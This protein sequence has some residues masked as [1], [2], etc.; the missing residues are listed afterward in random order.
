MLK[1]S[2]LCAL[3]VVLNASTTSARDAPAV[4]RPTIQKDGFVFSGDQ[5]VSGSDKSRFIRLSERLPLSQLKKRFPSYA[6]RL[7]R[8]SLD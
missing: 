5:V 7:T 3:A 1:Q 6:I 4:V 2:V 8:A